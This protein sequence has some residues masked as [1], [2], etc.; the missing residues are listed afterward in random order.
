MRQQRCGPVM[1][2]IDLAGRG[3]PGGVAPPEPAGDGVLGLVG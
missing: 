1:D 2:D 3:R